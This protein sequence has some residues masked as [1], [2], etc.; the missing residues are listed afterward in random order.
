MEQAFVIYGKSFSSSLDL[1][2]LNGVDGFIIN[3]IDHNN[4]HG[5]SVANAGDIN[6]DGKNDV[7]IDTYDTNSAAA[8]KSYVIFGQTAFPTYFGAFN[9]EWD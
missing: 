2:S 9:I 8:A 6:K 5:I 7:I 1:S 4:R 3:C